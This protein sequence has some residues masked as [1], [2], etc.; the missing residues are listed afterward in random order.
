MRLLLEHGALAGPSTFD[1]AR[2]SG[3]RQLLLDKW[4]R[5]NVGEGP[6]LA[7][8]RLPAAVANQAGHASDA[9]SD[10]DGLAICE[11]LRR[12]VDARGFFFYG[13]VSV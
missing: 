4:P 8:P 11:I 13:N 3:A 9:G 1:Y 5:L 7:V 6:S 2:S 10:E 12:R